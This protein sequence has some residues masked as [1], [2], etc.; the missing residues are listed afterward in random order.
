MKT[1]NRAKIASFDIET[2]PTK[3]F[4]WRRW[5]E[6]IR[7]DQVISESYVL[8]AVVKFRH[9]KKTR[10]VALPDFPKRWKADSED[11]YEVVKW[12][13]EILDESDVI[14]AHNAKKFDIPVLNARFIALGF[15]PPS[16][17]KI[18][19]TLEVA[20]KHFKFPYNS[21][22]AIGEYLGLGR[23]IKTDFQLW[24]DCVAGIK[25]AWKKMVKY[26]DQDVLLLEKVYLR[27]LPWISNHPN[28]ALYNLDETR[29]TCP[30]CF[31][32]KVE[33]RGFQTTN[34]QIYHR[35]RCKE[36]GGWGRERYNATPKKNKKSIMTNIA[37]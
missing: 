36:C 4:I 12:C 1:K 30:K 8:C 28:L 37:S 16:P 35:F 32:H 19:D 26:C 34:T 25:S 24:K 10:K 13:W 5:K 3:A 23:K 11:D 15:G 31:S 6:N 27:F 22:D 29:P 18:V 9:E 17:Y 21:L 20:K 2:S 7:L 33:W 14:I